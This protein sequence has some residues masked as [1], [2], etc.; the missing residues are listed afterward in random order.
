MRHV[1]A[2]QIGEQS[3]D[4]ILSNSE[5]GPTVI[6]AAIVGSGFMA[7][8][9]ARATRAA[10][11]LVDCVVVRRE[12]QL[13]AARNAVGAARATT[14]LASVLADPAIEIVHI[15]TPNGSH[16]AL[17]DAAI[18]AGKHVICEKPLA[19]DGDLADSLTSA[20][21]AG[22]VIGT[23]PFVYRF[24]PLVREMRVRIGAGDLGALSVVHGSYLQDWMAS[25]T[26]GNWRVD[27]TAGGRSR[28]F[29][30][31]GSHWCDL[32][33]F[34]TQDRIQSL[35]AQLKIVFSDRGGKAVHTED[36]ASV[37]FRTETGVIGTVVVAQ[38]AAGRKNRLHLEISGSATSLAFDQEEPEQLWVGHRTKT[39]LLSRDPQI[40]AP[41]AARYAF[42]PAGHAQGY[43]DCFNAFVADTHQAIAGST[44]SGLPTFAD[45]ARAARLCD[46]VIESAASGGAW[47]TPHN[48]GLR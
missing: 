21:K 26:D 6:K 33:E 35:S 36:A 29:A 43:Q 47:I 11:G 18:A 1:T 42:L 28:A 22:G 45:G 23:V 34:V 14:D 30:D 10:G 25:D 16:A 27:P 32:F 20:A 15:C 41:G 12:D 38:T 5:G 17:A 8:T 2:S 19:T 40:L 13:A 37:H 9:H 48:N 3:S 4:G 39:R 31:I 46:A 44:P 24:H 7:A